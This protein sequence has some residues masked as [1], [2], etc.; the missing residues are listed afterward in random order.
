MG[1][2][3]LGSWFLDTTHVD[4]TNGLCFGY[5][6]VF[7]LGWVFDPSDTTHVLGCGHMGYKLKNPLRSLVSRSETL[8]RWIE[9]L[10][11]RRV[12]EYML[13]EVPNC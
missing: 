3:R 7:G 10:S 13:R 4:T 5:L 11:R 1:A 6:W 8:I 9:Q 2:H 12:D